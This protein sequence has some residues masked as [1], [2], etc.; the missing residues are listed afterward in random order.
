MEIVHG[1]EVLRARQNCR[2][3]GEQTAGC[4]ELQDWKV[5]AE[6]GSQPM[7]RVS[8]KK[9]IA[10]LYH[11]LQKT[12]KPL[13]TDEMCFGDDEKDNIKDALAWCKRVMLGEIGGD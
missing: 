7:S 1:V 12:L 10:K 3:A 11:S 2:R 9:Q 6:E 5:V 8:S 4:E 13:P